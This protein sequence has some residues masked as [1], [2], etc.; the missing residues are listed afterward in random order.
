MSYDCMEGALLSRCHRAV[1]NG[2]VGTITFEV[3]AILVEFEMFA[4]FMILEMLA[5][6]HFQGAVSFNSVRSEE[7]T[8]EL[9]SRE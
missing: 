9:Q 1:R 7:H 3:L 5:V 2:A 8:S 6:L 4:F